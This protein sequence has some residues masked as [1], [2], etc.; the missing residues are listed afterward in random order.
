M[1]RLGATV[2][3]GVFLVAALAKA[4][5]PMAFA[6][7]IEGEGL[8]GWIPAGSLALVAIGLE[9]GLGVL[10][11]SWVRRLW[12]LVPTA[13]L[14]GFFLFLTGRAYW[15]AT[16]GDPEASATS[17]G[18][19]G[20]LVDRTPAEAFWQDLLLLGIPLLLAFLG[21]GRD[22]HGARWRVTLAGG[23]TVGVLLLAWK[24]PDLPLDEVATRLRP[25]TRIDELCAGDD[26][27]VCLHDV[28][29]ALLEGEHWVVMIEP[30]SAP[31]GWVEELNRRTWAGEGPPLTVLA[32]ATPEEL[33][34]VQFTL[35][36]AFPIHEAPS[37][38]LRPLYRQLPRSFLV[39]DGTVVV[40]SPGL[41]PDSPGP[42]SNEDGDPP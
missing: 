11:I 9:T 15:T 42:N 19:F 5:D 39:R 2:L 30:E 21:R 18:C 10:L 27:R 28:A 29:P 34:E 31:E 4:V 33:M 3:G 14:T 38:L 41:P 37:V 22:S 1:G 13:G 36:P 24:A 6:E 12:V 23:A 26:P 40:T 20:N 7:A 17:C 8:A 35:G 16:H 32:D 25:G